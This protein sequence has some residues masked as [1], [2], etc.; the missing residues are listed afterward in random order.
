LRNSQVEAWGVTPDR[1]E[2]AGLSVLFHR[3]QVQEPEPWGSSGAGRRYRLGDGYDATRALLLESLYYS[4]FRNGI[5]FSVPSPEVL[6]WL[7]GS[8]EGGVEELRR[9]VS[10]LYAESAWPLSPALYRARPGQPPSPMEEA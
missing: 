7:E 5:I 6:L 10:R 4:L 1:V 9:E 2:M 3:T 8:V